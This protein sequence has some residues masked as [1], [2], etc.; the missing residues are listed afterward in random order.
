MC[1]CCKEIRWGKVIV[2]A[3]IFAVITQIVNSVS[4]FLSMSYYMDPSLFGVWSKV[5]MPKEGPPPASFF[6]YSILFNF[7]TGLTLAA[8]Y[9]WLKD[10]LGDKC[11][12]RF[13][14]FFMFILS[15]TVVM[16]F[17]PTY[18]LINIP[19]ALLGIWFLEIAAGYFINF[20][21]FVKILK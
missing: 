12:S 19:I 10:K 17:L 15:L 14:T 20:M 18:L 7:L 3:V 2:C 16:F 13:C 11:G 9:D 4:A 5:M 6:M 8:T 21:I 1:L